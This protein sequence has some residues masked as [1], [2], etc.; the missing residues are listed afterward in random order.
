MRENFMDELRE[1]HERGIY[2]GVLEVLASNKS[3]P[4]LFEN[5]EV[6]AWAEEAAVH[7]IH[8]GNPSWVSYYIKETNDH[9]D[10]PWKMLGENLIVGAV[11]MMIVRDCIDHC[12]DGLA[13][14]RDEWKDNPVFIDLA[15]PMVAA[16]LGTYIERY[17]LE[18]KKMAER[19]S[20]SLGDGAESMIVELSRFPEILTQAR[21]A[22]STYFE[23]ILSTMPSLEDVQNIPDEDIE[24]GRQVAKA[25]G[26]L[27]GEKADPSDEVDYDE[28]RAVIAEE[29][30]KPSFLRTVE[31]NTVLGKSIE[32][33]CLA[34][35]EQFPHACR[36]FGGAP[37]KALT[38]D[39]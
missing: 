23:Y 25:L 4:K 12:A 24:F 16:A 6:R 5:E 10:K 34:Y 13:V 38:L 15:C 26:S 8:Q 20:F 14:V 7:L 19:G 37:T 11:G 27:F 2:T 36:Y 18:K 22:I 35:P 21:G 30:I 39:I 28:E 1:C 17:I 31:K 33:H 29:V 32:M 9:P 3:A